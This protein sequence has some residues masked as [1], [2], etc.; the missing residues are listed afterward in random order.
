MSEC[1]RS[2]CNLCRYEEPSKSGRV[3]RLRRPSTLFKMN[4]PLENSSKPSP[5]ASCLHLV[6]AAAPFLLS[7]T[8]ARFFVFCQIFGYRKLCILPCLACR[9]PPLF[10]ALPGCHSS[11]PTPLALTFLRPIL[12]SVCVCVFVCTLLP[13]SSPPPSIS[14]PIRTASTDPGV[15]RE[16]ERKIIPRFSAARQRGKNR[17]GY[18]SCSILKECL[19][20]PQDD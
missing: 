15:E 20:F 7:R 19:R 2:V 18:L 13:P 14:T 9:S 11:S 8:E 17:E 6:S 4:F 5:N 10:D 12:S 3:G 1:V 16:R